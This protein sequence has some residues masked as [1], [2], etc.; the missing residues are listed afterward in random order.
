[1]I[2]NTVNKGRKLKAE[3]EKIG[4]LEAEISTLKEKI[5][6]QDRQLEE[7]NTWRDQATVAK[8]R[9]QDFEEL[10]ATC[11]YAAVLVDGDGYK[12]PDS[13]IL[14][15]FEGGQQAAL[16]LESQTQGYLKDVHGINQ[17]KIIVR[18]FISFDGLASVYQ[19]LGII[20]DINQFRQF[21]IGFVQ[22]QGL[23]DVIDVG[24]GKE[25]A[26]HKM[27]GTWSSTG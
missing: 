4:Y 24:K 14:Q 7:Q 11:K 17:V 21:M 23:F 19:G 2:K 25:R 15:G 6:V 13:L 3:N 1:M 26:D 9:L 20:R 22:Y 8:Q 27:R 16:R 18:I 5:S 10:A 12:F